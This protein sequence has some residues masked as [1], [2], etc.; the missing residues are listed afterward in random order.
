MTKYLVR[1][2]SM[3]ENIE[4]KLLK[5][6]KLEVVS[7]VF[8]LYSINTSETNLSKIKKIDGVISVSKEECAELMPLA[9]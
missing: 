1:V 5:F 4:K 8:N 2:Y 3:N 9:I 7:R 6:G